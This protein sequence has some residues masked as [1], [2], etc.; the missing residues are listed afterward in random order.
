MSQSVIQPRI[1]AY[2]FGPMVQFMPLHQANRQSMT[3]NTVLNIDGVPIRFNPCQNVNSLDHMNQ[4]QPVMFKTD[5][6]Y[7]NLGG[8]V[9]APRF[10]TYCG[11]GLGK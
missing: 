6:P 10:Y 8:L 11:V 4:H 5:L 9:T 7:T 3:G 2:P 1:N